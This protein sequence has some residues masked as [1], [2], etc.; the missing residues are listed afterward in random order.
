MTDFMISAAA[1]LQRCDELAAISENDGWLT[2]RYGT[3][4]L[5]QAGEML[6]GWMEAAGMTV[7]RDAIG[8]VIG[9]VGD[10]DRR[11]LLIG[12]HLVTV[13]DAGRYDGML[14]VLVGVAC[15]ERL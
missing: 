15:V 14:G 8:N 9:R 4:A 1:V 12:S 6:R 10:A 3:P 13:R 5:R 7:R 11:T 2:R